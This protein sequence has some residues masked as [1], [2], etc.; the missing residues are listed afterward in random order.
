MG[1]LEEE[2]RGGWPAAW[3]VRMDKVSR[4]TVKAHFLFFLHNI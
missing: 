2:K 3:G 1:G 4:S